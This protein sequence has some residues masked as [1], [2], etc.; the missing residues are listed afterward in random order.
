M[1]EIKKILKNKKLL[2]IIGIVLISVIAVV[3]IIVSVT[4]EKVNIV[5]NE[6]KQLKLVDYDGGNFKMKIPQG[7]KVIT[8]GTEMF[9]AIRVYDEKDERNQ[10]FAVL[11]AE[12]FLKSQAAKNWQA[13]YVKTTGNSTYKLF[14]EAIV[15]S[16]ATVEN[17]YKYFN[18]YA[19][20]AQK[21]EPTYANFNFPYLGSFQKI[22]QFESNTYLKSIAKQDKTLRATYA[23]KNNKIAEGLFMGTIVEPTKIYA[24]NID[25]SF[26]SIYNV[27]FISSAKDEF[28]NY[29]DI[30]T[31]SLST[32]EY[33][34]SFVNAT[35]SAINAKTQ[36]AL[37]A[38]ATVQAAFDS[39]NNAWSAR[40]TTYDITSQKYS[41]ATLGYGSR[42]YNV[43]TG[44]VYKA[45][46]GFLDDYDG[47]KYKEATD[48]MY[49][50]PIAGYIEK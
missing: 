21:Y 28:I 17:F 40:Q 27:I 18:S 43:E 6:V 26:Y 30:L 35:N 50:N 15:L 48:D 33:K 20:Y 7:W 3:L 34:Q 36:A 2:L 38:N 19:T 39:Y 44:E 14:S 11:K 49:T 31:K 42:V 24:G 23:T 5:E 25:T 9:Y 37:K 1:E 4:K 46:N 13:W 47:K 45:Y 22:E 41:D 12:P 16:P 32:L 8:G 29:K 10:I